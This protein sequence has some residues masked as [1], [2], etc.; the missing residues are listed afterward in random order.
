M[1]KLL[2]TFLFIY[3]CNSIQKIETKSIEVPLQNL[4]EQ[5][6][7][8]DGKKIITKGFVRVEFE[9]NAIYLTKED[10]EN[11]MTKN[12]LWLKFKIKIKKNG[13]YLQPSN[14]KN[15]DYN[16]VEGVFLKGDYSQ[17]VFFSG[18]LKEIRFIEK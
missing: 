10:C 6:D 16:V 11:Y 3:S 2:I 1:K 14:F 15:N 17:Q 18:E 8:Y 13:I 5:P 7:K 12:A 9:Q 4:I